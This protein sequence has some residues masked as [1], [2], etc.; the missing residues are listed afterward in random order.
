ESQEFES[1]Y[2]LKVTVVPTN[3]P[4]IR[5]DE[6]DVVFRATNGKWRAAVVEISR[7]NKVGRPVLVGTTSVE[8]S[9]T[10]SEQLHEAG[11]PHEVLN[12]KPE[13]VER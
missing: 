8:Q 11:I 13:N 2:K 1:I 5:K 12:A 9:E 4:M 10:L 3:K 6:S 7:M